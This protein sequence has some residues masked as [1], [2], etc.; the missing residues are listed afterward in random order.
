MIR[1]I[2]ILVWAFLWDSSFSCPINHRD[3]LTGVDDRLVE[4]LEAA[5]CD[6]TITIT[7]GVR[8]PERQQ[9]L[10]DEGKSWTL[11]SRHLTGNAV[12][13]YLG[14]WS[15]E[16]YQKLC[17]DLRAHNPVIM[18]GCDWKQVDCVHFELP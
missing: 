13:V 3:R 9:I 14:T 1:L 12:D 10:F 16:P 17:T 11:D 18:C 5:A 2:M 15:L 8:K 6:Y 4:A 7:E